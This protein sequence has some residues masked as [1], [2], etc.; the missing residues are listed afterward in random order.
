M[1]LKEKSNFKISKLH[2]FTPLLVYKFH[3]LLLNIIKH[4]DCF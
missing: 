1:Y 3:D 4:S 2:V